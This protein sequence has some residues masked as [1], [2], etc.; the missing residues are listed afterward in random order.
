MFGS[1]I[2]FS[3][4]ARKS[5]SYCDGKRLIITEIAIGKAQKVLTHNTLTSLSC[6]D[7]IIVALVSSAVGEEQR[8]P[9]R[10]QGAE[11]L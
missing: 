7:L 10:Q 3:H 8:Q 1:G 11:G 5:I 2:Y 6:F 9:E 4:R